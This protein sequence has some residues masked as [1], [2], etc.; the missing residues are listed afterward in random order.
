MGLKLL[1]RKVERCNTLG[2]PCARRR[3]AVRIGRA[4]AFVPAD[5][6][7]W[8]GDNLQQDLLWKLTVPAKER[9]KALRYF[10]KLNLNE[11]TL[12]GSE[13]GLLEMLAA[14]VIDMRE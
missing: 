5:G 14:N 6:T 4:S 8:L 1:K 9:Q 13:E 12:F 10:H 11:F 2:M 3:C 7:A